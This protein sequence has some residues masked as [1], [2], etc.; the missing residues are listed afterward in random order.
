MRSGYTRRL[1]TT[2]DLNGIP[3]IFR[4]LENGICKAL[5]ITITWWARRCYGKSNDVYVTTNSEETTNH[6]S[7]R[8]WRYGIVSTRLATAAGDLEPDGD[9]RPHPG[10]VCRPDATAPGRYPL[11]DD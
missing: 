4:H 10:T 7:R 9:R 1:A 5:R 3:R 2:I 6:S 8:V 11:V